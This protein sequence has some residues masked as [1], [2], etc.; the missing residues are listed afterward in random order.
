M[1]PM[2]LAARLAAQA[3]R[4]GDK[5][6]FHHGGVDH[7]YAGVAG[8]AARVAAGLQAL[9]VGK[10]DRVATYLPNG[11]PLVE[12]Y[13]ALATLGAGA[14]LLNPQLTPREI[15]YIL[16]DS[17]ARS[18]ITH[19]SLVSNVRAVQGTLPA[20]TTVVVAGGAAGEGAVAFETL[21]DAMRPV[22]E[23]D[24]SPEDEAWLAYTSGTT[25]KPKGA[26]LTHRNLLWTAD[27]SAATVGFQPDDVIVCPIPLFHLFALGACFLEILTVGATT[28]IH[29]RFSPEGVLDAVGAH[30]VTIVPGV[31]TMY[32]YL[33]NSPA[34]PAA[35]TKSLRF[36]ITGGAI[37]PQ[38]LIE[39]TESRLGIHVLNMYGITETASWVSCV[40]HTVRQ[41]FGSVGKAM[42]GLTVRVVDR[43]DRDV[44]VGEIGE[45][46][47]RGP[48][49]MRGYNHQP[50]ATAE[51]MRGGFYHTGDLGTL[52]A[53]GFVYV[54]DRLKDMII[55]GGYNI[56]PKEIEDVLYTHPAVLEAAVVG[57]PHEA[58]GEVPRAYV[59]PKDGTAAAPDEILAYLRGQLAAYKLPAAVEII[60]A[61]P[62]TGSGKIRR[63]E[64]RDRAAAGRT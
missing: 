27:V 44:P 61:I 29:D 38:Q 41:P 63:V 45:I 19:A 32:A 18:I 4:L 13:F 62:K 37:M 48:N 12:S 39:Q 24:V 10:G 59:V 26:I 35:N 16:Q 22:R 49:V 7:A 28:V 50:Q 58:K 21:G 31:P 17:G 53:D 60:A 54:L 25:G 20:L 52:D 40:H 9:G 64:L 23:R 36:G 30:K 3:D 55:S 14:V 47:V 1:L 46:I 33:L 5:T 56:Y 34:L 11:L 15:G 8:R 42:P 57:V 6:F 51:A 43:D 2:T